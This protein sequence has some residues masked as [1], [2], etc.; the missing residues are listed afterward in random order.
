MKTCGTEASNLEIV[1]NHTDVY[2]MSFSFFYS[3]K[4]NLKVRLEKYIISTLGK[5]NYATKSLI[6]N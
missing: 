6:K 2:V 3:T 1:K 4:P 5:Q